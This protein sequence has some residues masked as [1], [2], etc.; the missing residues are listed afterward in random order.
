VLLCLP[1]QVN[2]LPS[3]VLSYEIILNGVIFSRSLNLRH[4]TMFLSKKIL[5]ALAFTGSVI[6]A[7]VIDTRRSPKLE[8][9]DVQSCHRHNHGISNFYSVLIGVSYD[10]GHCD[11]TYN[12]LEYDG[13][14]SVLDGCEISNWQCV[15]AGDGNTQLWFNSPTYYAYCLNFALENHTRLLMNLTVLITKWALSGCY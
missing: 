11:T 15:E 5:I 3:P 1:G 6:N 4:A 14:S 2:K 8:R 7:A 9:R 10:A 13:D 12:N